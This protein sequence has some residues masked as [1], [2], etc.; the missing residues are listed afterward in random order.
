TLSDRAEIL[1]L[2]PSGTFVWV[3]SSGPSPECLINGALDAVEGRFTHHMSVISGPSSKHSIQLA[4]QV[5][6]GGLFIVPDDPPNFVEKRLDIFLCWLNE[7]FAVVLAYIL[8]EK[9]EA[10]I[11]VRDNR[12][13][14]REFKPSF[15][16]EGYYK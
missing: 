4:D 12:L 10:I 11:D 16:H 2:Y 6:G 3:P 9:V 5:S 7:Q 14:R 15:L 13:F 1:L 8:A